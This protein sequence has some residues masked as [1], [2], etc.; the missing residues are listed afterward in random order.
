MS[1]SRPRFL[2]GSAPGP[3]LEVMALGAAVQR[4]EITC[5]DGVR[6]DVVL[7]ASDEERVR[8][9]SYRGA[10]VGRYANRIAHGNLELDGVVHQ[11]STHERG[12]LLH[13]GSD[14]FDRR[15]W[16]VV[17]HDRTSVRLQLESP[18]AIRVSQVR[19]WQTRPTS[20]S[21]TASGSR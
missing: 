11:L 9:R 18:E 4:L 17:A 2:L 3:V 10:T 8:D 5:G 12:H 6:R 15:E 1:S 19:W 16:D 20:C 21:T 14:G 13:G 7:G